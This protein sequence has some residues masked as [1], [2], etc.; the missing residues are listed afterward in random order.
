MGHSVMMLC[1]VGIYFSDFNFKRSTS[2]FCIS[3]SNID[4][5]GAIRAVTKNAI[6]DHTKRVPS[7]IMAI[8]VI[9]PAKEMGTKVL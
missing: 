9:F 3:C 1:Q 5:S 6:Y 8:T 2:T 7:N 4:N